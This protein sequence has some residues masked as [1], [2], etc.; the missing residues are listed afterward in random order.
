MKAL[1]MSGFQPFTGRGL[2]NQP[3]RPI[4][5]PDWAT[6][7]PIPSASSCWGKDPA[8][9]HT[10]RCRY[11]MPCRYQPRPR[12]NQVDCVVIDTRLVTSIFEHL[13]RVTPPE[14]V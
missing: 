1:A 9:E 11:E 4:N 5:G 13:P 10:D 12:M 8:A 2:K 14:N 7:C 3:K 6:T